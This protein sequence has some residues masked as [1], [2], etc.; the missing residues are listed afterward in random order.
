MKGSDSVISETTL[1]PLS[2]K[3]AACFRDVCRAAGYTQTKLHE[4][5]EFL[6]PPPSDRLPPALLASLGPCE[7][8]FD[9]LA[10]LFFLGVPVDADVAGTL[11]PTAI[12]QSCLQSGLVSQDESK[13]CP[14]ATLVP[15]DD[16]LFAADLQRTDYLDNDLFVPTLCDA[17]LHLNA[18]AIHN[19]GG[20]TLD[21]CSGF[22]LHGITASG[23]SE[24]VVASD[25]NP[26]AAEFARFNAA[27]NGCENVR[28][29][30]GDLFSA[31]AGERFDTIL[32]NP[33]FII[34]PSAVT[35]YRYS[36][37]ELDGFIKIMFA[38]VPEHLEEGGTFQTICEWVELEGQDWQDR[39]R[40]WFAGSG[41][42]V[43]VL[44]ANR[45]FPSTY[46]RSVLSQSIDDESELS[47][48]Q[49]QW[50]QYLRQR[51]VA[52]IQGGFIFLRRRRGNNWFD[53]T[54]LT[55][56]VREPIGDAIAQGFA[57]RDIVFGSDGDDRL[58]SSRLA[59]ADGLRQV[60]TS[61]WKDF[62]WKRD[63]I[64]LHLDKG[65][66]VT[67]GIDGYIRTLIEQFDA[68]RNVQQCLDLFSK[69]IGLPIETG[70]KKGLD[71]VRSML[72]NGILVAMPK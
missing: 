3:D 24:S 69:E 54:E 61:H 9:V 15:V 11:L 28:A 7:S 14:A 5:F 71:V 42:D 63:S 27:L 29:V 49:Q 60:E 68:S 66:P 70:R 37:F 40:S 45:Q 57:S 64:V 32:A 13:L 39:L 19:R 10:R 38:A 36:P 25:L 62:R 30:T 2:P 47:T 18:V 20:K 12:V 56:P 1:V 50:E 8:P 35:T 4:T 67:I 59:V 22:A 33:P 6:V 58:L 26:R 48:Q 51:G 21:L 53:F 65:L 31:V 17:A 43:W 23:R 46:A 72:K 41:C 44:S 34:S 52:A 55:K 16:L